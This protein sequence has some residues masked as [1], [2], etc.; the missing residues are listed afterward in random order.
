M[1]LGAKGRCLLRLERESLV[2]VWKQSVSNNVLRTLARTD[3]HLRE[4]LLRG[5][6]AWQSVAFEEQVEGF[7]S[8]LPRGDVNV[9]DIFW[10]NK[11]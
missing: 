11:T 2:D 6:V 3:S 1:T 8:S 7:L 5:L 4:L 9:A 10:V